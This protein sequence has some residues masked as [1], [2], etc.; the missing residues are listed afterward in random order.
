MNCLNIYETPV[1]TSLIR[2]YF[3]CS[4]GHKSVSFIAQSFIS[5]YPVLL[6]KTLNDLDNPG[7]K[8]R[9]KISE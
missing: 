7:S 1:S 3:K 6:T 2:I 4:V 8:I 5:S 9:K